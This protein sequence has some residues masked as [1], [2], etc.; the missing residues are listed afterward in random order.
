M[1]RLIVLLALVFAACGTEKPPGGDEPD[2]GPVSRPDAGSP[3]AGSPDAGTPDSGTPDSGVTCGPANCTGC[4]D[5]TG[6]CRAGT[7]N[8]A[9]GALGASCSDCMQ[10]V[11]TAGHCETPV[12]PHEGDTCADP[13]ALQVD[14]DGFAS[15][16]LDLTGL[17][18][19]TQLSCGVGGAD[20]VFSFD[21]AK[22]DTYV[23]LIVRSDDNG[24]RPL[25]ALRSSCDPSSSD[26]VCTLAPV[27]AHSA[28]VS[29]FARHG[30]VFAWVEAAGTPSTP[31]HLELRLSPPGP[32][33]TCS[34]PHDLTLTNGTV[35]L[36]D[37]LRHYGPDQLSCVEEARDA[38]YNF[39][40]PITEQ[41]SISATSLTTGFEPTI[42]VTNGCSSPSCSASGLETS[43]FD[44]PLYY[45]LYSVV[46]SS[47]DLAAGEFE[48]SITATPPPSGDTCQEAYPLTFDSTG[49]TYAEVQTSGRA[50][51]FTLGCLGQPS[52]PDSVLHFRV[53]QPSDFFASVRELTP[54]YS[55]YNV[56]SLRSACDGADL[57]CGSTIAVANLTPGDYYV[58]VDSDATEAASLLVNATL[59]PPRA[60]GETCAR[61]IPLELSNGAAGG[62]AQ[63]TGNLSGAFDDIP[64]YCVYYS[65]WLDHI[66]S[67]T[68]DR[69]L[70]VRAT[71]T[72]TGPTGSLALTRTDE[73]DCAAGYSLDCKQGTTTATLGSILPAGTHE[74]VIESP[75]PIGYT[76][77]VDAT[78]PTQGEFCS[79]PFAVDLPAGGGTLTLQSTTR[80]SVQDN[81]NNACMGYDLPDRVYRLTLTD[82]FSNLQVTSTARGSTNAPAMILVPTCEDVVPLAQNCDSTASASRMLHQ[83]ALAAGTYFLWVKGPTVTGTDYDLQISATP[84]LPGDTCAVA[85]QVVLSNGAAGGTATLSGTTVGMADDFSACGWLSNTPD[86]VYSITLDRELDVQVKMTPQQSTAKGILTLLEDN[87]SWT[88]STCGQ[89]DANGVATMRVG[90]MQPGTHYVSVDFN[91]GGPGAYSLEVSALPHQPGETCTAPLPLSFSEGAAGGTATATVNLA[92]FYD[93]PLY[94]CYGNGTDT[95][96]SFTTDRVLD[97]HASVQGIS[98]FDIPLVGL[99]SSCSEPLTCDTLYSFSGPFAR[100][101]L[102][103]GTYVLA[104]DSSGTATGNLTLQASLTP[105]TPGDTCANPIELTF[106]EA[107]GSV[108]VTGNL[109][110]AFDNHF[111]GCGT[112]Y[113]DRVY[114]F[115]TTQT[116][117][118]IAEATTS[119]GKNAP[120]LTLHSGACDGTSPACT[121][122]GQDESLLRAKALPPGT[123]YLFVD[124]ANYNAPDDY[125]LK[126][127]LGAQPNGDQCSSAFPLGLPTSGPGQVTVQGDTRHFFDDVQSACGTYSDS[128]TAPD[129]VYTFTTTTSM[130]VRLTV[131]ALTTG[132]QPIVSLRRGCSANDFDMACDA[133][134][135]YS[136]SAWTSY[137]N[138]P[139]GTYYVAI[140][141]YD[142]TEAG[143][144]E[145]SARLSE[146]TPVGESCANPAP[147][148]LTQGTHGR[149]TLTGSFPDYFDDF[150][151]C[152][153][154]FGGSDAVFAITTDSPRLLHARAVGSPQETQPS[155]SVR[156]S[157][158]GDSSSQI[159]CERSSYDGISRISTALPSGTS[160]LMV[161]SGLSNPTGSFQLEVQVDDFEPGDVC[162]GAIPLLLSNGPAG[163]TASA[164]ADP[165]AFASDVKLSCDNSTTPDTFFTFT[166]DRTLNLSATVH[167]QN[168]S[169]QFSIGLLSGCG[170]TESACLN[171]GFSS[172]PLVLT[173]SALPAGTYV[174]VVRGGEALPSGFTLDVSLTP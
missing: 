36:R 146:A 39:Y 90:S 165:Y 143:A 27:G 154:S 162:T 126:V 101:S 113:A 116:T 79:D 87:C 20:A 158:C 18:D 109:S 74:F 73:K 93:D 122:G 9:C 84:T 102:Q 172:A 131:K 76:L 142:S 111:Q 141:G 91:S 100:G 128:N 151:D 163:G 23:E 156:R 110:D 123:Y 31:L 12:Q 139:P 80:G 48:L 59:T 51:D 35:T 41:V 149:A 45:G 104:V 28:R 125:S 155:L 42:R 153:N 167:R 174:L 47:K 106:P 11:C 61:P 98:G 132:F 30:R 105:P 15:A 65:G 49:Q 81:Y 4:C 8:T 6:T 72:R 137:R 114:T 24:V 136:T 157:P 169:E 112:F 58:F 62:T 173:K 121:Y 37:D 63:V 22:D 14:S 77:N 69:Q 53:D 108:T 33:D 17:G 38:V 97:L 115:T 170:G 82:P 10:G 1:R 107:G 150:S 13:I 159:A 5:T 85:T 117:N 43:Q 145:L 118:L 44:G 75:S 26:A 21:V 66:Y 168:T 68:T 2:S 161:K 88:G 55:H 103:P 25:V 164:S 89:P 70:I 120:S 54:T 138:L 34:Q 60:P 50:D 56:I 29:A 160:Y 171:S 95:F 148:T 3:D 94:D 64:T 83:T 124:K 67:I 57:G 144:Y 119:T 16:T 147:V 71:A 134:P 78:P 127:T 19:E 52:G 86:H 46:V 166:T 99:V 152:W 96:Y 135:S 32:G 129:T 140:D 7:E 40:L 133:T 92:S 130:N